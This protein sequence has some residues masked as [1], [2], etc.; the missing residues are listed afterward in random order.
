MDNRRDNSFLALSLVSL[1]VYVG[2]ITKVA[3]QVAPA[4]TSVNVAFVGLESF[5]KVQEVGR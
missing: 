5:A 2:V 1:Y 4:P 3:I